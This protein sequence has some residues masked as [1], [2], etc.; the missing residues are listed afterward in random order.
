MPQKMATNTIGKITVTLEPPQ[1]AMSSTWWVTEAKRL[2]GL[3]CPKCGNRC[4]SGM[5]IAGHAIEDNQIAGECAVVNN[6]LLCGTETVYKRGVDCIPKD[7]SEMVGRA[8][9]PRATVK[10]ANNHHKKVKTGGYIYG[11]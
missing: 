5:Y 4:T 7:A 2:A 1:Q 8:G 11:A 3:A 6:C 9:K 10:L